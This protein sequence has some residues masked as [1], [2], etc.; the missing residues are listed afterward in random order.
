MGL[1]Q[2]VEPQESLYVLAFIKNRDDE[3]ILQSCIAVSW[4]AYAF[5]LLFWSKTIPIYSA[6]I[7]FD[8]L[9]IDDKTKRGR[10]EEYPASSYLV[11]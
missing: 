8:R 3:K 5:S 2:F 6:M 10:A 9:V 4:C 11:F 1:T 7:S